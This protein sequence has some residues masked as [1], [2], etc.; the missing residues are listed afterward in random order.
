MNMTFQFL[1]HRKGS[2]GGKYVCHVRIDCLDNF[3]EEED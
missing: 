2:F 3:F 1:L